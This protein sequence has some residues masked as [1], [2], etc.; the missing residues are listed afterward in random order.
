M[1]GPQTDAGSVIEAESAFPRLLQGN[2]QPLTTPQV[3]NSLVVQLPVCISRHRRNPAISMTPELSDQ[4]DHIP[5]KKILVISGF[6]SMTV[7]RKMLSRDKTSKAFRYGELALH[8]I[9]VVTAQCG[10]RN[11]SW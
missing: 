6:R 8:Q 9:N 10:A 5:G 3:L 1:L 4:F 7:C 2:L 11:F